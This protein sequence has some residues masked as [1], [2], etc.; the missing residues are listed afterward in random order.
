MFVEVLQLKC[1]VKILLK[2]VLIFIVKVLQNQ[3]KCV[4]LL[5]IFNIGLLIFMS[6]FVL[7]EGKYS[8]GSTMTKGV[9]CKI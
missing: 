7:N 5:R 8:T 3:K 6:F 4:K 2:V 9:T 1:L